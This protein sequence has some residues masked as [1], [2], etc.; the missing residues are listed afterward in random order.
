MQLLLLNPAPT[1]FPNH[2]RSL[3]FLSFLPLVLPPTSLKDSTDLPIKC[4]ISPLV[5]YGGEVRSRVQRSAQSRN[6]LLMSGLFQGLEELVRGHE[7]HP[8]LVI[9]RSGVHELVKN[10]I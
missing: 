4:E 6:S 5:S 1:L 9:D 8:T 2:H 10:G 3:C 7:F